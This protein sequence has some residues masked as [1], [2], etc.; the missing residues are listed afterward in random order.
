MLNSFVNSGRAC[1]CNSGKRVFAKKKNYL[2]EFKSE[3]KKKT[4]K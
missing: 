3:K 1:D 4:E 2:Q